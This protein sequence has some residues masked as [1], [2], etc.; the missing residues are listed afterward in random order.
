M[1]KITINELTVKFP[2]VRSDKN[3]EQESL[4]KILFPSFFG[5]H[6]DFFKA[7]DKV[8]FEL[9]DGDRL[10]LIGV[11]GSGKSTLLKVLANNIV[12]SDGNFK[13]D[14][15]ITAALDINVGNLAY[16]TCIE[17]IRLKGLMYGYKGKKLKTYIDTVSE[18]SQLG[19]FL[20]SPVNTLSAGMKSRLLVSMYNGISAEILIMDEWI[21][22][23]DAKV[24]GKDGIL[25][26]I[27]ENTNIFVLASHKDNL[28]KTICNKGMVLK[29][30]KVMFFGDINEAISFYRGK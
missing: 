25:T 14:G 3:K 20:N 16:A 22:A 21:G 6:R 10:A 23:A 18:F 13:V 26:K 8:S 19:D 24:V 2:I 28:I 15:K 12:P 29:E 27:V 4:K 11:N 30:G 5:K 1:S 7:L 17:N 9:N